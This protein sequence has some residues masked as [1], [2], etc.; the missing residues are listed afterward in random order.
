MTDAVSILASHVASTL[1]DSISKRKTLLMALRDVLPAK[2][3]ARIQV[4]AQL[5][6]LTALEIMQSE[7][8]LKF[9]RA[10][11]EHDGD[12]AGRDGQL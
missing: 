8:P 10:K 6:T 1:P 11:P 4:I 2:H 5:G 12:G 7:L 3:P 9:S